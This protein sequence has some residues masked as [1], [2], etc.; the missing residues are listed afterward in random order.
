MNRLRIFALAGVG[1]LGLSFG[2]AHAAGWHRTYCRPACPAPVVTCAPAPVV[3][4]AP[5]PGPAP[6]VTYYPG[7]RLGSY[8]NRFGCGPRVYYH[9]RCR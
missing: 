6:V 5:A 2:S 8:Y 1:L 3:T 4:C 7:V 9:W